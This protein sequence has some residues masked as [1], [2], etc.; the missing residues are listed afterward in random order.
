MNAAARHYPRIAAAEG[1]PE[2]VMSGRPDAIV[3]ALEAAHTGGVPAQD[4][5]HRRLRWMEIRAKLIDPEIAGHGGHILQSAMD[6]LLVEFTTAA[7]A[8]RCAIELQRDISAASA[9]A[10]QLPSI[11]LRI[12]ITQGGLSAISGD[13]IGDALD[14]AL[15]LGKSAEPGRI[16]IDGAVRKQLAAAP[17]AKESFTVVA[18]PGAGERA[19]FGVVVPALGA[20]VPLGRVPQRQPSVA[21]LPFEG[22]A[23][24]ADD[25][26][27]GGIAESIVGLLAGVSDLIVVSR[28]S[29]MMFRG[30]SVDL[31]AVGRQLAVRYILAGSAER[32]GERLRLVPRLIDIETDTIIWKGRYEVRLS[33][34]FDLQEHISRQIVRALIPNLSIAELRRVETKRPESLDAYDLV[35]QAMDR[36]QRLNREDFAA[37]RVLLDQAVAMDPGYA[38]AHTLLARWYMLN[39]GQ[40]Y[41]AREHAEQNSFLK[42][43]SRAVELNPADAHALALLGHC[44]SW[45]YRDYDAALDCFELAFSASP[46]SAFA[47][48]WSSPT[49]SYL[50]DGETAV[51][52]AEHAL[53]LSPLGPNAYVYH[54]A[55]ALGHYTDGA[56]AEAAR[57]GRRTL[58]IAP[59]YAANLRILVASLA[60]AGNVEEAK[61]MAETLLTLQPDF[62]ARRFALGY[63]FKAKERNLA[64]AEHL[65]LAGLKE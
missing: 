12:A 2:L 53:R 32:N 54:S 48:G 39:L 38:A 9:S 5:L 55:L 3:L 6:R 17:G 51:A 41:A 1:A 35:L 21:V 31:K 27:M 58:A 63:S 37:A 43:V 47:W 14:N 19:A 36:M 26:F 57:W 65:I 18:L 52:H 28:E 23:D 64:L 59:G 4:E 42:S 20:R 61:A 49:C 7:D 15:A 30:N 62:R 50:G 11:E 8:V 10:M 13:T 24:G 34:L 22:G 16:V 46:N 33:R 60:A 56:Y 44:K 40:G 29:T 25:Y 45:L